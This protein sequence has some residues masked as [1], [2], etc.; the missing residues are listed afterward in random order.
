MC[1]SLCVC[2][3]LT[4][5][6][7]VRSRGT[8]GTGSLGNLNPLQGAPSR[9]LAHLGRPLQQECRLWRLPLRFLLLLRIC[10]AA[11][12]LLLQR[13]L[14]SSSS[15]LPVWVRVPA[16]WLVSAA[17]GP[18]SSV[19]WPVQC[20]PQLCTLWF[21]KAVGGPTV[22]GAQRAARLVTDTVHSTASCLC[23]LFFLCISSSAYSTQVDKK[24]LF[25]CWVVVCQLG[26]S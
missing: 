14:T 16:L 15:L 7:R 25:L 20:L 1:A 11:V 21:V 24:R 22:S 6:K 4:D 19:A 18:C 17:C 5:V 10:S 13:G 2:Q 8:G 3:V 12:A 9:S 26:T 23:L